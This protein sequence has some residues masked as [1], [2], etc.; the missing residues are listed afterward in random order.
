MNNLRIVPASSD[1]VPIILSLIRALGEYERMS[2][3]SLRPRTDCAGGS[4]A[5]VLPPKSSWPTL[6]STVVGFALFFHNFST[7]LGRPGLYLED[8][9]VLP[10][11]RSRGI[12]QRLLA[13]LAEL[14]VERGCGRME[15]TVL[16]WNEP[17]LRFYERMGA[18][19]MKEW[20]LCRLTGDSLTRVAAGKS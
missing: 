14:A 17:A 1:D 8:L 16:D 7:F 10:E 12:G 20:K 18:R 19:V 4:L 13:H 5:S 11:W 15:W 3:K 6:T 9:F 2:T